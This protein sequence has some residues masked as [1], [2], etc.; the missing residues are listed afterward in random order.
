MRRQGLVVA[1]AVAMAGCGTNTVTVTT[2]AAK[3]PTEPARPVQMNICDG[4][5][6]EVRPSE[7]ILTC[8]DGGWRL[9]ALRWSNWGRSIAK[10]TGIFQVQGCDPDCADDNRTYSYD[11]SVEAHQP[12]TCPDGRR[13][14]AWLD[15]TITGGPLDQNRP[16]DGTRGVD[17]DG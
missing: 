14:Y 11:V 9:S 12:V 4:R 10:A 1:F 6:Y 17:C 2:P 8:G 5:T 13:Q 16:D 7:V 3:A 15:W